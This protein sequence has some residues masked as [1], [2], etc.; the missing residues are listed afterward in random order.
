MSTTQDGFTLLEPG[1]FEEWLN[2]QNVSRDIRRVQH[3]HTQEPSYRSFKGD[4]HFKWLNIMR[5][6]HVNQRG[7]SAIAQQFTIFPDGK[8]GT[9]RSLDRNP[10]GI[11]GANSGSICIENF[12]NFDEGH[13]TM[14]EEQKEAIISVTAA[15]VKK[16]NISLDTD[17]II[18]HHWFD[19]SSGERTNGTGETKTCPG[20]TFFGGNSVSDC[21]ENLLPLVQAAM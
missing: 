12:G 8:I 2:K 3:H 16:F 11:K 14:R 6:F 15:L 10:A 5:D 9:G 17:G 13:D 20:T 7:F 1:E 21:A 18:Y 4:D 19:R